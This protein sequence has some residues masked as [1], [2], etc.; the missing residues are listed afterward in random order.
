LTACIPGAIPLDDGGATARAAGRAALRRDA[1][2]AEADGRARRARGRGLRDAG[3]FVFFL[4]MQW[5]H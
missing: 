4:T 3:F 1:A 5:G 2:R